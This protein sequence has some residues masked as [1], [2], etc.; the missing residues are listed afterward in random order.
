[1][2]LLYNNYAATGSSYLYYLLTE[3]CVLSELQAAQNKAGRLA[4]TCLFI[5]IQSRG[6]VHAN[7]SWLGAKNGFTSNLLG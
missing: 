6:R 7:F 1:M 5:V 3:G 2:V 4:L